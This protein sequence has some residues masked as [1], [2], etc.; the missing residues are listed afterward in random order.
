MPLVVLVGGV[1]RCGGSEVRYLWSRR[2]VHCG[3]WEV[4]ELGLGRV[5]RTGRVYHAAA[6]L[7]RGHLDGVVEGVEVVLIAPLGRVAEL[8]QRVLG[9]PPPRA[10]VSPSTKR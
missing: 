5:S 1:W 6:M 8:H 10:Q 4:C 9:H 2:P 7:V 3:Y